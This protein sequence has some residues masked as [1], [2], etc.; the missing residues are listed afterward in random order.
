MTPQGFQCIVIAAQLCRQ[1]VDMLRPAQK[2]FLCDQINAFLNNNSALRLK[3][4]HLAAILFSNKYI[5][6]FLSFIYIQSLS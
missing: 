4:M 6:I 3:A 1:T 5:F 2:Q